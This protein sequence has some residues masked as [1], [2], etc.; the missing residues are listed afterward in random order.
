MH[1]PIAE[2]HGA[3]GALEGGVWPDRRPAGDRFKGVQGA[4]R[5]AAI[6]RRPAHLFQR[7]VRRGELVGVGVVVQQLLQ[8][9]LGGVR[10]GVG[11]RGARLEEQR[12]GCDERSVLLGQAGEELLRPGVVTAS[13]ELLAGTQIASSADCARQG[14]SRVIQRE[15]DKQDHGE[16]AQMK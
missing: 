9:G 14:G 3:L 13:N 16:H 5:A 11:Q 12:A 8:D 15:N 6:A 4:H 2:L 7:E 10:V 1:P